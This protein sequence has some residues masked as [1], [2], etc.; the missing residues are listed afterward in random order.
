MIDPAPGQVVIDKVN[1][2]DQHLQSLQDDFTFKFLNQ[3]QQKLT[4]ILSEVKEKTKKINIMTPK[5]TKKIP[6]DPLSYENI[7]TEDLYFEDNYFKPTEAK[8]TFTLLSPNYRKYFQVN[9]SGDELIVFRSPILK[10]INISRKELKK[11]LVNIIQDNILTRRQH[12]AVSK[13]IEK[14][15]KGRNSEEIS[16]R[17][18]LKWMKNLL[19]EQLQKESDYY[20]TGKDFQKT[21]LRGN[22]KPG[23]KKLYHELD[24]LDEIEELPSIFATIPTDRSKKIRAAQNFF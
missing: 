9:I 3:I 11:S 20:K 19:E 8:I 12:Q 1:P 24:E 13:L 10:T 17:I 7:E 22:M 4:D 14:T 15:E 6:N 2:N 23:K 18:N 16:K 21:K 5:P